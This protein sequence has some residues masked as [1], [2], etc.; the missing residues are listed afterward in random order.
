MNL[1]QACDQ[2]K[3]ELKEVFN[4]EV[5]IIPTQ[6]NDKELGFSMFRL[7]NKGEEESTQFLFDPTEKCCI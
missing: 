7:N 5:A 4:L 1:F 6:S 2:F 3:K